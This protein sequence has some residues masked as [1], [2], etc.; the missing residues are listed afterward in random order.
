MIFICRRDSSGV[1]KVNFIL[2]FSGEQDAT[3]VTL[4]K[5]LLIENAP[6]E[7]VNGQIT[8]HVGGLYVFESDLAI[9]QATVSATSP[10]SDSTGPTATVPQSKSAFYII[11][12]GKFS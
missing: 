10:G 8:L 6:R 3:L 11:H 2:T 1:D 12:S 7:T 4:I 5:G 9:E